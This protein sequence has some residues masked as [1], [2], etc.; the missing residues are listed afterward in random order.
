MVFSL[1]NSKKTRTHTSD[2][3]EFDGKIIKKKL[4]K[5]KDVDDEFIVDVPVYYKV[6]NP[7]KIKKS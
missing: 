2:T 4:P 1:K 3:L 7:S 6:N 5:G